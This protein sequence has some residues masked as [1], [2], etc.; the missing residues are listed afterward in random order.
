MDV[1]VKKTIL[2]LSV[3][4]CKYNFSHGY[5]VEIL[6][7]QVGYYCMKV[8]NKTGLSINVLWNYYLPPRIENSAGGI[9]LVS[10]PRRCAPLNA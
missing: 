6:S 2:K 7:Y 10:V 4:F 3:C 1:G 5:S 8:H 9:G